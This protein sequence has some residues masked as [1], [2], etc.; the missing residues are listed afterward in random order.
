MATARKSTGAPDA[1]ARKS[2]IVTFKPKDKRKNK[3][4]DKLELRASSCPRRESLEFFDVGSASAFTIGSPGLPGG[5][6]NDHMGFDINLFEAPILTLTLSDAEIKALKGNPDVAAVETDDWA[7][8]LPMETLVFEG[9]PSVQAETVPVGVSQI[10]APP[11]W[12][13]SRGR[14]IKVAVLDTGID[15]NHP[16]LKANVKGAVSF[17]PGE[18]AMDGNSH[19]THCAGTI[20]AAINGAGVVGVAPE[21]S[22]YG[23]KVLANNG[24]GQYSWIIAGINWAIQNKMQI[25]SMSLGGGGAP[26]ALEAICDA[27]YNAGVLLVAAAGNA[28]PGANT[29]IYPGK[30]KRVIAVS[31]IDNSNVIASFSSR[32]PE[33]E[34]AAP[35][36]QVLSTVPGGGYGQKSGTSMACPH[37]AGAA[38]VVWGAHRFASNTQIWNLLASTADALGPPGWDPLYGYGRV[39]VDQAALAMV[40]APAV[41]FKP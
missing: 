23:V 25:V 16:D 36:V 41:A 33:I 5:L 9:Q 15:W 20:G 1:T 2:V 8:A 17:V 12:G 28:G 18:T 11:A 22:L 34:I 13:C 14:G 26:A 30:Y 10:K 24:S 40:P 19:G 27:A 6:D 39:D 3:K 7:Y 35:G 38:A 31:A 29:V 37:V 21:A 32:G 4:A